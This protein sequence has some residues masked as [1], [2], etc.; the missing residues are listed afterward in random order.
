MEIICDYKCGCFLVKWWHIFT[1]LKWNAGQR[2]TL[3]SFCRNLYFLINCFFI[4]LRTYLHLLTF[5]IS[6]HKFILRESMCLHYP[7][8]IYRGFWP[9]NYWTVVKMF[10]CVLILTSNHHGEEKLRHCSPLS[11]LLFSHVES[12][13]IWLT[14]TENHTL[15]YWYPLDLG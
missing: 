8:L 11:N 12:W 9:C 4:W 10:T 15:T 3:W 2:V 6:L 13:H 7:F 5:V 1:E 14:R